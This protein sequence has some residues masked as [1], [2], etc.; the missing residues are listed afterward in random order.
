MLW[1]VEGQT[2][3]ILRSWGSEAMSF[4]EQIEKILS[5]THLQLRKANLCSSASACTVVGSMR[6]RGILVETEGRNLQFV[7]TSRVFVR[8]VGIR[9]QSSSQANNIGFAEVGWALKQTA[10][11]PAARRG[12]KSIL[13]H[14]RALAD[15][16]QTVRGGWKPPKVFIGIEEKMEREELQEKSPLLLPI[17]GFKGMT[18]RPANR[19]FFWYNRQYSQTFFLV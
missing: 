18:R 6:C 9:R 4:V 13:L 2:Q 14:D 5:E 8:P 1:G 3:W 11:L 12:G 19:C 16:M 17:E 15:A 7:Q 10:D